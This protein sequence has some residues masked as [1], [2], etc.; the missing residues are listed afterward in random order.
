MVTSGGYQVGVVSGWSQIQCMDLPNCTCMCVFCVYL[1]MLYF[2]ISFGYGCTFAL[3]Y[4]ILLHYIVL[5]C[6]AAYGL[7][8]RYAV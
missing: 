7:L 4:L 6:I 1:S 5:L 2:V 3:F 8:L